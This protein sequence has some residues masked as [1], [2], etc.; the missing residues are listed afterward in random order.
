MKLEKKNSEFLPEAM[1]KQEPDVRQE[2]LLSKLF[3]LGRKT[4][5]DTQHE[6][7]RILQGHICLV[8]GAS[9]GIGEQIAMEFAN[10]GASLILAAQDEE[11]LKHVAEKCRQ[12]GAE[13][14]HSYSANLLVRQ[15]VENLAN[16]ILKNHGHIHVLINNAGIAA[17]TGLTALNGDPFEW[18]EMT[19]LNLVTPMHLTRKFA[20]S[21][22][23][24][25]YGV[26]INIGSLAGLDAVGTMGAYCATKWGV[27]GWSLSLHNQLK[28]HG[29]KVCLLN[30]AGT[31]TEFV[32]DFSNTI[33]ERFLVPRDIAEACLLPFRTSVNCVP[34]EITLRFAKMPYRRP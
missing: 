24:R 16:E 6:T 32:K 4:S 25:G 15:E 3:S 22:V 12:N 27:R 19:S 28:E 26:I 7:E 1:T 9:R 31:L 2:K 30:P 13:S 17:Q 23:E 29:I 11:R 33:P 18:E 20:P 14:C 8:T 10:R 21:M 34:S 5:L